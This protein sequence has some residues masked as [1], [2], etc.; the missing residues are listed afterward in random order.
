MSND[1]EEQFD[2]LIKEFIDI[3]N[4][5]EKQQIPAD[6]TSIYFAEGLGQKV[7]NHILTAR[8]LMQG[9]QLGIEKNLY[10]ARIDFSSI[11]ILTRAA[12]ETYLTFHHVF[13]APKNKEELQ[14]RFIC[15][16]IAGYLDR[17]DFVAT[18]EREIKL[19]ETERLAIEKLTAELNNNN[20]FKTKSA[21]NKK[22]VLNGQWR[23]DKSWL[24]LAIE[25][26]FGE[27]FFKQQ[28]KFLCGYAH[29]SRLSIIQIQQNKTVGEQGEMAKASM[30]VL[31]VILS[32]FIHDYVEL[33]PPL[34]GKKEYVSKNVLI[35][36]W[37][38]VGET[39]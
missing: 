19:K 17:A 31:M 3:G 8:Y 4:G 21:P 25:A 29:S 37:K 11:A 20:L 5:L 34:H 14:F 12:L 26:G 23:L 35:A 16:D 13:I 33:M 22:R 27:S 6:N 2:L 32:K 38:L 10:E 7:I 24:D 9:F 1:Y 28:Y 15:W 30:G 39:I 36:T 18:N